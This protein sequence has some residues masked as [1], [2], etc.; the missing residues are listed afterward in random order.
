M[1]TIEKYIIYP[2]M[3]VISLTLYTLNVFVCF[4]VLLIVLFFSIFVGMKKIKPI[5]DYL[6]V[7]WAE[8]CRK[9]FQLSGRMKIEVKY[10]GE[11]ISLNTKDSYLVTANHQSWS[12]IL[13]MFYVF[14][15][16]IPMLKFFAKKQLLWLPLVGQTCWLYGFPFLHRHTQAELK[17]HPEWRKKDIMATKKACERFKESPGSLVIYAEG[18]RFTEKKR[19]QQHGPYQFLLKPK[20][21]GLSIAL[22]CMGDRIKTLLDVTIVYPKMERY[23]FWD[24]CCGNMGKITVY[25]KPLSIP[26][27]LRGD[28]ENDSD[29]R[30]HFQKYIN[31]LWQEKDALMRAYYHDNQVNASR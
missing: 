12:D 24:Y 18:T 20:T 7:M 29:H 1:T 16:K 28:L 10:I 23:T 21:G 4:F 27:D 9:I 31:Q 8:F 5:Y 17:K 6:P 13:V 25:V 3:G 19:L 22:S 26:N 11:D 14:N 2:F 30:Q 15:K